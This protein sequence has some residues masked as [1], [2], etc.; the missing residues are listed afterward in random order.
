MVKISFHAALHRTG[1]HLAVMLLFLSHE[2]PPYPTGG[3]GS[4]TASMARAL[5]A[6]GHGVHVLS[7]I[8]GQDVEDLEDGDVSVHRRDFSSVPR[9]LRERVDPASLRLAT[10]AA[11]RRE[12]AALGVGFDVIES[13]DYLAPGLALLHGRTPVAAYAHSPG[14]MTT[15]A[16]AADLLEREVLRRAPMVR[17][18]SRLLADHLVARRWVKPSRMHVMEPPIELD[19]W[20]PTEIPPGPPMVL[21]AGRFDPV[22]APEVALQ[23]A[24]VLKGHVPD[25]LFR[26]VGKPLGRKYGRRYGDWLWAFAEALGVPFEVVPDSPR[27]EMPA[28][29]A[30]ASVVV[31]PSAVDNLPMVALEALACG[32]AVV[33]T[34]NSGLAELIPGTGAG[35]IVPTGDAPALAR[36]VLPFVT[37]REHAARAGQRGRALVEERFDP[38]R[39]AASVER[40]YEN[41]AA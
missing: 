34:D 38:D 26:F 4:Y 13:P 40:L 21:M 8:A 6:R 35:E 20:T 33:G 23:A 16:S 18:P 14:R 7:C 28:Q 19:V 24:A 15:K 29:Y 32:R 27:W 12:S 37:D 17:C 39:V 22:K 41:L 2:Y 30:A 10:A 1:H 11:C 5:A 9:R 36:A 3:I 31:L 25:V